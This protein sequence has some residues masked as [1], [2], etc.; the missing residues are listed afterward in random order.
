MISER[1]VTFAKALAEG[2]RL[3]QAAI[4]QRLRERTLYDANGF[5][6]VIDIAACRMG[7]INPLT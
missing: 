6:R 1:G 7:N 3:Y 4:T 5:M 2:N